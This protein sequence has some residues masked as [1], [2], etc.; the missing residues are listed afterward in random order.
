MRLTAEGLSDREIAA[1]LY[2][3]LATVRTHLANAYG[4]LDVGSR[5]SAVA[6]AR[7]LGIV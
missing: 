2:I 5:T 3:G 7:R 6:A 1:S 4:K